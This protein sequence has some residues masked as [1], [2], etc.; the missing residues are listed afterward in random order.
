MEI[1]MES[2]GIKMERGEVKEKKVHE[3]KEI[4]K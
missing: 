2:D 4:S 1:K 3:R